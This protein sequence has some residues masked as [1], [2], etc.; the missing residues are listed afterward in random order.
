MEVSQTLQTFKI[1][2]YDPQLKYWE[3]KSWGFKE[4]I[5]FQIILTSES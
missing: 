2:K 3:R 5:K 4:M 1:P